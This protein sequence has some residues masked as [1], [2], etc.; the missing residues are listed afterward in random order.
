LEN[1]YPSSDGS[2]VE[3]SLSLCGGLETFPGED[4]EESDFYFLS[5]NHLEVFHRLCGGLQE[6]KRHCQQPLMFHGAYFAEQ[7]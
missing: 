4:I 5:L 1:N 3:V 2:G 6:Q 7:L